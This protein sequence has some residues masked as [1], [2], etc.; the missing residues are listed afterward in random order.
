M[1]PKCLW[2]TNNPEIN[3]HCTRLFLQ[4]TRFISC[5]SSFL[6]KNN[7]CS[8]FDMLKFVF[9]ILFI[10]TVG[11]C[12][13]VWARTKEQ[14]NP[15][16]IHSVN[17]SLCAWNHYQNKRVKIISRFSQ[18]MAFAWKIKKYNQNRWNKFG[19]VNCE[20]N[21]QQAHFYIEYEN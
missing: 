15:G 3:L 8:G 14:L 9:K 6:C 18:K 10:R 11:W 1:E 19:T 16:Y 7:G 5:E 17:M 20:N 13:V 12:G 21:H 2:W 4:L